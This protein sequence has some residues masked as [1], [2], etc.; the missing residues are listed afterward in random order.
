MVKYKPIQQ[1]EE[2][3]EEQYNEEKEQE[4]LLELVEEM[5]IAPKRGRGRPKK[6][7]RNTNCI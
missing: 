4:K 5:Q 1:Q 6:E 2:E 7:C 3:Q